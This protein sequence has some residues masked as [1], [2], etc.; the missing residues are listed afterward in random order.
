MTP[1]EMEQLKQELEEKRL[2]AQD[3]GNDYVVQNMDEGR[4]QPS[5]IAE[6]LDLGSELERIDNLLKGNTLI[7]NKKTGITSWEEPDDKEL[8]TLSEY[9]VHLVRNTIAW[10]LNKNTLLSNYDEATI[11]QKME[12]FAE[13]LAGTI[14]MEYDKVF[15]YPTL[16]ECKGVLNKRLEQRMELKEYAIEVVKKREASEEEKK[17]IER[18]VLEDVEPIIEKELQKIKEQ[19]IKNKLKRFPMLMREVQDAVHS[20]YLRAWKGQERTTLRQHIHISETKGGVV[21]PQ[22]Q[23]RGY[24][25]FSLLGRRR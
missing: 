10:Y 23:Q 22:P 11:N 1:E 19:I 17:E 2:Q 25:P 14:F 6:Q 18:K 4:N 15:R 8:I 16:D 13:D 21:M 3:E 24:G 12:D 20:T 7:E 5:M 9:G